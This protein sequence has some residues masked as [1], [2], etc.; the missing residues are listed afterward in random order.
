MTPH[1][2]G[3]SLSW[4]FGWKKNVFLINPNP[5]LDATWRSYSLTYFTLNVY[6]FVI[7]YW[8][9]TNSVRELVCS[10][11]CIDIQ[12]NMFLSSAARLCVWRWAAAQE[13]CR[14]SW[15][16][17]SD[18][19]LSICK[20]LSALNT[21]FLFFSLQLRQLT[22]APLFVRCTDVN[23]AAA[24]CTAKTA[25]CNDVPLQPVITSLVSFP[26]LL[27]WILLCAQRGSKVPLYSP[28]DWCVFPLIAMVISLERLD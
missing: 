27:V 28:M 2:G 7:F 6:N 17:S 21:H 5:I 15:R 18:L 22:N 11:H 19:Q 16:H 26:Y 23:P 12:L 3:T 20:Q 13:W 1:W 8:M 9:K 24:Q 10:L 14:P 4:C 25:S